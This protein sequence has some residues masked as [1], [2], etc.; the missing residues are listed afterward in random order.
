[1]KFSSPQQTPPMDSLGKISRPTISQ[2]AIVI[3]LLFWMGA[4]MLSALAHK[5]ITT[6]EIIHIPAG[7]YHLFAGNYTINNEHPPLVKMIAALPMLFVQPDEPPLH[8]LEQLESHIRTDEAYAAFWT[9]NAARFE[10]ICFWARVPMVLLTLALGWLIFVFANEMGNARAGVLAVALFA[11]EP[12]ILAHGRIVH[13]D[14]PAALAYL[15]FVFALLRYWQT[16]STRTAWQAGFL[17]GIALITKFS[18]II[19]GP[20]L[21]AAVIFVWIKRPAGRGQILR[22][23][24]LA[25]L[26]ILLVINLAYRFDHGALLHSDVTWI[27]TK[28]PGQFQ[29]ATDVINFFA[30]ILPTYFLYGIYNVTIHNHFGHP[31]ALLGQYSDFGWWYY[32]PVAFALK[33]SLPFLLVTI[34]ALLWAIWCLSVR[35]D[36]RL[37]FLLAP[38]AAYTALCLT[39]GINIGVRHFLPAFP[40]LFLLGGLMLD[41]ILRGPTGRVF[42]MGAVALLVGAMAFEAVRVYPDYIPYV[43]QLR[44]AKQG[45][46]LLSDSNVEWGDDVKAMSLYLRAKGETKVSAALAAGWLTTRFYGL[47]YIDLCS[48]PADRAPETKHVAI[49]ASFLNGSTVPGSDK[50]IGD[51]RQDLFAA[52]RTRMPEAIF[53]NSIFLYRVK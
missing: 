27:A 1:M 41:A 19:V 39:S 29:Q 51:M 24:L 32:F 44:G 50:L 11:F 35:S 20:L 28:T 7:Y 15:L 5:S 34:S 4:N 53:G 49:G 37:I 17:T 43:N 38:L 46:E 12:T 36:R 6:D 42:R 31:A 21:A 23:A 40:F 22:H 45:W 10:T 25:A 2:R 16:P 47:E 14:V 9:A 30:A 18:L 8:P 48:L 33:T 13:T 52:Y 3:L 26:L